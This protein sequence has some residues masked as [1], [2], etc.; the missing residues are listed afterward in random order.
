M[1]LKWIIQTFCESVL[2]AAAVISVMGFAEIVLRI[3]ENR[4]PKK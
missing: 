2:I 1:L 4:R 3:I